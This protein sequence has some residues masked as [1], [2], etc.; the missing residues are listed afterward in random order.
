MVKKAQHSDSPRPAQRC[1]GYC[2]RRP[3]NT[4]VRHCKPSTPSR[5]SSIELASAGPGQGEAVAGQGRWRRTPA[6]PLVESIARRCECL[7][8]EGPQPP[9]LSNETKETLCCAWF[10]T[11]IDDVGCEKRKPVRP[12]R[13]RSELC[14][15]QL[16]RGGSPCSSISSPVPLCCA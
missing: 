13:R 4:A 16:L 12:I 2:T 15:R 5:R 9:R 8:M 14:A 11:K 6:Q 7:A 10:A 1:I 3:I